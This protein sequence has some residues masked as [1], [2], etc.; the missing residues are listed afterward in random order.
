MH[1][2]HGR[3]ADRHDPA[4]LLGGFAQINAIWQVGP[5]E[6]GAITAGAIPGWYMA[7]LDGAIRI[8]P[9]W[10]PDLAGHPRPNTLEHRAVVYLKE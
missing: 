1:P 2:R 8:M 4:P 5:F 6:P 7:F 3:L 9:G 10:E